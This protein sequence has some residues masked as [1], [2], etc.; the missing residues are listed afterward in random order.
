MFHRKMNGKTDKEIA[1]TPH[2]MVHEPV[3]CCTGQFEEMSFIYKIRDDVTPEQSEQ[4][5]TKKLT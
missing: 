2:F 1:G 4:I 3:L 5:I